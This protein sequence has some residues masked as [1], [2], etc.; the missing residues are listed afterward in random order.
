MQTEEFIRPEVRNQNSEKKLRVRLKE[1][2]REV[3]LFLITSNS[4]N[5]LFS[6]SLNPVTCTF[7]TFSEPNLFVCQV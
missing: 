5:F 2:Q 7:I 6:L 1:I 4:L 3:F